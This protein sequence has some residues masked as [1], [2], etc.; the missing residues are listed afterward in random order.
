M[1]RRERVAEGARRDPPGRPDVDVRT[2]LLDQLSLSRLDQG[3]GSLDAALR[4]R[5]DKGRVPGQSVAV[6]RALAAW[7]V[8]SKVGTEELESK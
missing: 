6:S 2:R 1:R 8:V 7:G 5:Q 4:C 3:F